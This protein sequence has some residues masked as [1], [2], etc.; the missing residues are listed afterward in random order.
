MNDLTYQNRQPIRDLTTDVAT[1]HLELSELRQTPARKKD[2]RSA[3]HFKC[4]LACRCALLAIAIVS[5][6][7]LT[8][9]QQTDP[10][11][12]TPQGNVGI[13]TTPTNKLSV[14]GSADL[15][16]KLD[17]GG[18]IQIRNTSK[19]SLSDENHGLRYRYFGND[20]IDGPILYGYSGGALGLGRPNK[21]EQRVVLRWSDNGNVGIG[22]QVPSARLTVRAN[23]R[24]VQ[25]PGEYNSVGYDRDLSIYFTSNDLIN[26]VRQA[27]LQPG[28]VVEMF[29]I[30]REVESVGSASIRVKDTGI[31]KAGNGPL[32]IVRSATDTIFKVEDYRGN[33]LLSTSVEGRLDVFGSNSNYGILRVN[34]NSPD[35]GEATIGF[36]DTNARNESSAWVAGVGGWSNTGDFVIG[37]N[38]GSGGSVKLL[39]EQSGNVGIGTTTPGKGKLEISGTSSGDKPGFSYLKWLNHPNGVQTGGSPNEALSIYASHAIGVGAVF[40]F[41]DERIK[42]IRGR[43]DGARDLETLLGIEIT[44]YDF[45]DAIGKGKAPHKKVIGQ[46]V[47]KVFPEAVTRST[48]VV[49]DIYQKAAIKEGWVMLATNLRKGD[50]VRMIGKNQEGVHEVLEVAQGKFRTAFA[51]EGEPV[52]VYGR[53]VKDFRSVDYDAISMLNVSAT[54]QIKKEKDEEVKALQDENAALRSQL[55]EQEK[56]LAELEAKDKVRD[57]KLA[58][59]QSL[60]VSRD[61]P[62]TRNASLK[63]LE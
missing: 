29:G 27:G 38:S 55:A 18:D 2:S 51:P 1:L 11:T 7:S 42:N 31:T 20:D 6:F 19:I 41:S 58:A 34:R 35:A 10:L 45:G 8:Q 3:R 39:I 36:F 28:D 12:V 43:S 9:A 62:T 5:G 49:P 14:A 15:S 60:L 25:I 44:D 33:P 24:L 32:Y 17:V 53:E 46:Q 57:E 47:E 13:G 37:N 16:G 54:Q 22:Q 30:R 26:N 48:D 63:K 52:F 61:Q 50:R 4:L 21:A 40:V 59:I 56:R 23:E